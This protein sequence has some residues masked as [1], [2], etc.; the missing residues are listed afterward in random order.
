MELRLWSNLHTL[1]CL[2][3]VPLTTLFLNE[4]NAMT[5][6]HTAEVVLRWIYKVQEFHTWVWDLGGELCLD[7]NISEVKVTVYRFK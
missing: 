3:F 6:Q 2:D 5:V 1:I 4:G 7:S